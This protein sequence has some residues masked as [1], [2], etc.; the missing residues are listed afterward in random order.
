MATERREIPEAEALIADS[1]SDANSSMAEFASQKMMASKLVPGDL[2]L[3]TTGDHISILRPGSSSLEPPASATFAS[4]ASGTV[5]ADIRL[6][7]TT[8]IAFMG[9]LVRSGHGQGIVYATGGHTHFGTIAAS[10]SETESPRTPLQLSMD[11]LGNQLSQASFVIIA[12]LLTMN[13]MTQRRCGIFDADTPLD[14]DSDDE[15]VEGKA[16]TVALRILRIGN[17]AN[18]A[19]LTHLHA[20][21]A[22]SVAILT[23][24]QGQASGQ[25]LKSRWVGQRLTLQC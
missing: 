18:N 14:V 17:I 22:S 15:A 21:S 2:V 19:R 6:N 1:G 12:V 24:T 7:S 8:N 5:G 16:D 10:V 11:A 13:H 20:P 4:P 25:V 3:F 23:S 9:T